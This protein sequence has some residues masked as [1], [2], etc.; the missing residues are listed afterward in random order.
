VAISRIG[1]RGLLL[2]GVRPKKGEAGD[3][4]RRGHSMR[5]CCS[6]G[7]LFVLDRGTVLYLH[8]ASGY[9]LCRLGLSPRYLRSASSRMLLNTLFCSVREQQRKRSMSPRRGRRRVGTTLLC[10]AVDGIDEVK[11]CG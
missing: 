5:S 10:R 3:F 4:E 6:V 8:P 1:L 9:M 2:N 11:A 7:K